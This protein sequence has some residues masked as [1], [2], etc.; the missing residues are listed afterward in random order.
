MVEQ[1]VWKTLLLI[2]K[3]EQMAPRSQSLS[4]LTFSINRSGFSQDTRQLSVAE[5]QKEFMHQNRPQIRRVCDC[6]NE[7]KSTCVNV[8]VNFNISH[9]MSGTAVQTVIKSLYERKF[10]LTREEAIKKGPSLS[11]YKEK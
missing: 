9:E 3:R 2:K 5:T 8:S 11:P 1:S 4:F 7:V 6:T 10:Y